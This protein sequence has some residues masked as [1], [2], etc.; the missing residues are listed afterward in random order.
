MHTPDQELPMAK[1]MNR[2]LSIRIFTINGEGIRRDFRIILAVRDIL[3]LQY[4][5]APANIIEHLGV[6]SEIAGRHVIHEPNRE[7]LYAEAKNV[8]HFFTK[9][10]PLWSYDYCCEILDPEQL[11]LLSFVYPKGIIKKGMCTFTLDGYWGGISI[12]PGCIY[13]DWK[14][15]GKTHYRDLRQLEDHKQIRIFKHRQY[16]CVWENA[17]K[18]LIDFMDKHE[19]CK[20]FIELSEIRGLSR[21]TTDLN[22]SPLVNGEK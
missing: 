12:L 16:D 14:H 3:M 5:L 15:D 18:G 19:S 8:L 11:M 13:F 4:P 2:K 10:T 17:M 6:S 9:E 1:P 21:N 20:L 7:K 22:S